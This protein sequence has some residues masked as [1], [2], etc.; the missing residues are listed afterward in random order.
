VSPHLAYSLAMV[1]WTITCAALGLLLLPI[2]VGS[3]L[4]GVISMFLPLWAG[5]RLHTGGGSAAFCGQAT[6]KR[7]LRL[8]EAWLTPFLLASALVLLIGANL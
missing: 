6:Q 2:F 7:R 5:T 4:L 8:V 3:P 1:G